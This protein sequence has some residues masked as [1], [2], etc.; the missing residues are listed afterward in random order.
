M[1]DNRKLAEFVNCLTTRLKFR[2]KNCIE[3]KWAR[4]TCRQKSFVS[5]LL[6]NRLHRSLSLLHH[7]T[8]LYRTHFKLFLTTRSSLPTKICAL[9]LSLFLSLFFSFLRERAKRYFRFTP[10]VYRINHSISRS[11]YIY[12]QPGMCNLFVILNRELYIFWRAGS[13]NNNQIVH[14]LSI[15][16]R[17]AEIRVILLAK[18]SFN[19][20]YRRSLDII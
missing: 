11:L 3:F 20:K 12:L 1:C 6:A 5:S 17:Y 2:E 8:S 4:S 10:T 16:P 15:Y 14:L 7:A 13:K 19:F 18:K 9:S